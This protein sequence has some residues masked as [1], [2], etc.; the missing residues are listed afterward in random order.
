MTVIVSREP[1]DEAVLLEFGSKV[2]AE[3]LV[4]ECSH[5]KKCGPKQVWKH[6]H[7]IFLPADSHWC[8]ALATPSVKSDSQGVPVMQPQRSASQ[9]TQPGREGQGMTWKTSREN[10][11]PLK[12]V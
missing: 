1:K 2:R 11:T 3:M 8:L 4:R 10:Y 7:H 9:Y 6:H 5:Y 12:G